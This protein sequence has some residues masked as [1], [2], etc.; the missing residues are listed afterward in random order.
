MSSY[1]AVCCTLEIGGG[2]AGSFVLAKMRKDKVPQR[3]RG[4][5]LRMRF[6]TGIGIRV[7]CSP[8]RAL[9]NVGLVSQLRRH[10]IRDDRVLLPRHPRRPDR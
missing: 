4:R 10:N 8:M 7:F 6:P 3:E 2:Q 1:T 5:E 9:P